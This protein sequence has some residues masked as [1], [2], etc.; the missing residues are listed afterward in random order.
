MF[1]GKIVI[2]D[3]MQFHHIV[4]MGIN[5]LLIV[6]NLINYI[7]WYYSA[8]AVNQQQLEGSSADKLRLEES[9]N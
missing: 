1:L 7:N 8:T 6:S 5:D 4:E 9:I 3:W 2:L